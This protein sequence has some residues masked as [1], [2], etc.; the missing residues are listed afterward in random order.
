MH[1]CFFSSENSHFG[2]CQGSFRGNWEL[3][4]RFQGQHG[5]KGKLTLLELLFA[6]MPIKKTSSVAFLSTRRRSES[7][8]AV[9][10]LTLGLLLSLQYIEI[11]KTLTI[12]IKI[13]E[14][15]KMVQILWDMTLLR[16]SFK[17]AAILA[18]ILAAISLATASI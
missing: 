11:L 13:Y 6:Q 18:A 12:T 5:S 9:G 4:H 1:M 10:G 16:T 3:P 14:L 7:A 17:M 15:S 8:L 2:K